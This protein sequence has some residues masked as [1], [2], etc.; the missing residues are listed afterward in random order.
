MCA[1]V[2]APPRAWRDALTHVG[3]ACDDAPRGTCAV[4]VGERALEEGVLLGR[5]DRCVGGG[6][7]ARISR[8]HAWVVARD[9]GLLVAD[10][11]STNGTAVKDGARRVAL[12]R[13]RRALACARDATILLA[14]VPLRL[15]V[16]R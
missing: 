1:P 7:D 8:V 5:L 15:H 16:E 4:A 12:T 11:G 2:P 14:G 3:V 10:V 13:G 6:V 9:G